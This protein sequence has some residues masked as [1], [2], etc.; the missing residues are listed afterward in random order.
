MNIQISGK[1]QQKL[2]PCIWIGVH[3]LNAQAVVQALPRHARNVNGVPPTT[4]REPGA[5][6]VHPSH[7]AQ[8]LPRQELANQGKHGLS[9][10]RRSSGRKASLTHQMPSNFVPSSVT[11]KRSFLCVLP[12]CFDAWHAVLH[13]LDAGD[14]ECMDEG[15]ET[16]DVER[17]WEGVENAGNSHQ[18]DGTKSQAI[19]VVQH[20]KNQRRPAGRHR[21]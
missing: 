12:S 6:F 15:L 3:V 19:G 18:V 17:V 8:P 16:E 10:R 1:R 4:P 21:F 2:G 11:R 5:M 9:A 7:L 14:D 13:S 20:A